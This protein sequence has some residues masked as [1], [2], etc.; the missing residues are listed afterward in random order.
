MHWF[1]YKDGKLHADDVPV[2]EIALRYDTPTYVYSRTTLERHIQTIN[3][4]FNG[5]NHLTCYSVKANSNRAIVNVMAESGLG[6]DVVSGG[7]LYRALRAGI[8]ANRIVY[9]GVG[10]TNE[11]IRYALISGILMFN[12]ESESELH[13][14]NLVA[15]ET[16]QVAPISIRVNPDVDPKTHPYISTGLKKNKFGIPQND[17]L[18][19]YKIAADLEHVNIIGIDAHIGSQ[20]INV[21]PFKETA[22]RLVSL[23]NEIRA[24]GI[25]LKIVDIGGGLGINY[26]EEFPP[27]PINWALMIVPIIKKTG[28][29]LIIE[30]GRSI[31]GNAGILIT[32]VLYIKTN[33]EK[34]FI[35]VDA[36][37]NDLARPSLYGSYHAVVPV[38]ERR[39]ERRIVDVVG[40]ICESSDFIARDREMPMPEE[41]DLLAIMSAGAYGMSMSS[42]YNSRLRA[43][44]ILVHKNEIKLV[45]ERETYE[46]LISREYF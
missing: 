26:E 25:D 4:A 27:D 30:P 17:T 44:E 10:K 42:N 5:I 11:E 23:I 21:L 35:V 45:R 24:H 37:M 34:T 8:P 3:G 6:A 20:L 18:R 41:G 9:S 29:L 31:V 14:I 28:C 1:T 40:P 19:I 46:N 7:E 13:A 2:S 33:E 16:N 12:V 22:E 43:A 36:G 39:T 32:R 15:E 38:V